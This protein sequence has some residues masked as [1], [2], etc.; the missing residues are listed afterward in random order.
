MNE[1]FD[2]NESQESAETEDFAALLERYGA[3][4]DDD[5]RVGDR[6]TGRVIAVGADTVF[7]DTGTKVD[8]VVDKAELLDEDGAPTVAEGDTV[9]LFV[10]AMD[11]SEIRLS[12]AV[13]GVGG[14]HMLQEA[15]ESGMPVEG[16][17]QET[18]KGGFVVTVLQRRAFCPGSQIDLYPPQ[19]AES[20]VGQ[21]FPFLVTRLEKG[22]R[23]IVLT[24]R[25]LLEKEQEK[26]RAA[27]LETLA[28][29]AV[30]DGTVVRTA[31]F[32]AFVQLAP[33]VDGLVHVSE[34]SWSRVDDPEKAVA[35]G[36][37]VRVKVLSMEPDKKPGQ[38]RISLSMKQAADDPWL[39]AERRFQVGET[40]TGKVT[41]LVPFGAF[42]EIAEGL[43]GLVHLSE[44][45]YLKRVVD[46]REVVSAGDPATVRI[47]SIDADKRR[48]SLSIRE[49]EGDPWADAESRF[50]VGQRVE[51][52]LDKKERFGW[53]I[54][55]TPGIT[56]LMP[57]S[58]MMTAGGGDAFQ[59]VKPG[60]AL[61]VVVEEIRPDE[62][63]ITLA[64]E[65]VDD[66]RDWQSFAAPA[67]SRSMGSLGE[68]LRQAMKNNQ[69]S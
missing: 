11:E 33:G 14:L 69:K 8:G 13:A 52:Y 49:A 45:S 44:M 64:P 66:G 57:K 20:Y 37:S 48:I 19:E 38:K 30:L 32:G 22:G 58:R 60:D 15:Q 56:G 12:R 31:P 28:P 55:L 10:V 5:L 50:K 26:V 35:V 47:K 65:G 42:V 62:R 46:P 9:S 16:R 67:E 54:R 39:T 3:E 1:P 40:V 18:C 27:F 2:E 4:R 41:R 61:T 51:G 23:N 68:K 53:F 7:V 43:E 29:E 34:M 59:G 25:K 24:R 21:T 17:V 6:V 63:K 36:E